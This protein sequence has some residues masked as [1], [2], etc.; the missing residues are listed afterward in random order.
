MRR[1]NLAP[2]VAGAVLTTVLGGGAAVAATGGTFI[3]GHS[4]RATTPTTLTNPRGTALTLR[5]RAARPALT[6]NT[7]ARVPRL[8]ADLVDGLSGSQLARTGGRTGSV[9]ASGALVDFSGDGVNDAVVAIARC[10][11]GT[12]LTGGGVR[13][14]TATGVVA[15]SAPD[16]TP[17]EA[18]VVA[19]V[20]APGSAD[21]GADV[22][23]SAV[24]YNPLGR[25]PGAYGRTQRTAHVTSQLSPGLVHKM[26]YLAAHR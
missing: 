19:V 25:V 1:T 15:V 13:D 22:T 3:L 14:F 17:S 26:R 9:D 20:I 10:P 8:N 18:W 5:A 2:F 24:C 7:Q 21:I 4:N 6:V 11:A 23:A 12:Q 16:A